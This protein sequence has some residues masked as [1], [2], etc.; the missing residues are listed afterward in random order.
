[1]LRN[2]PG[3]GASSYHPTPKPSPLVA[4]A[5]SLECKLWSIIELAGEYSA[6]SSK[7]GEPE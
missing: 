2:T 1:M 4:S 3:V 6:L 5:P 7:I